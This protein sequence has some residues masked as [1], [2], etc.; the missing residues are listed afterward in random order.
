MKKAVSFLAVAVILAGC[1]RDNSVSQADGKVLCDPETGSAF[2]IK[3]GAG[4]ISFVQR[5]PSADKLCTIYEA[6]E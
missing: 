1:G 3:P 2:F 6:V 4:D 5:T